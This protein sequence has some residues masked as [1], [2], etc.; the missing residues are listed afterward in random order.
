[1][2]YNKIIDIDAKEILKEK[3]SAIE[4][5]SRLPAPTV[6]NS[7]QY[8][9]LF[10]RSASCETIDSMKP[11]AHLN[12]SFLGNS[13]S[14]R[15]SVNSVKL[16]RQTHISLCNQCLR[17][18]VDKLAR[19]DARRKFANPPIPE[20]STLRTNSEQTSWKSFRG[21]LY[22]K[23]SENPFFFS[24][25]QFLWTQKCHLKAIC[26]NSKNLSMFYRFKELN[27]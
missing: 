13:V 22:F 20:D 12:A 5:N 26:R 9:R 8:K 1:M 4:T 3:T 14:N 17:S 15:L 7:T 18:C 25:F 23:W 19:E 2:H 11:V 10:S 21:R 24:F 6:E 27:V 16:S